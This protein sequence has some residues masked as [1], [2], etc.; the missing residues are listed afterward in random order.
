[1]EK[2]KTSTAGQWLCKHVSA[3][4]EVDTRVERLLEKK[5]AIEELL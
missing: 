1:V 5:N 2:E 4:A 3:A